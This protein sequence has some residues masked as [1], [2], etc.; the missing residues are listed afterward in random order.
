MRVSLKPEAI[1]ALKSKGPK[2]DPIPA[3][4]HQAY[5]VGVIDCGTHPDEYQGKKRDRQML[6]LIFELPALINEDGEPRMTGSY[7][8][9]SNSEKSTLIKLVN[10]WRGS[11]MTAAQL[12]EFCPSSLISRPCVVTIS[13]TESD[14]KTYDNVVAIAKPMQGMTFPPM[15]SKPVVF[16]IDEFDQAKF[17]ALPDFLKDKIVASYEYKARGTPAQASQGGQAAPAPEGEIPW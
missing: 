8:T 14:G 10:A 17:D 11:A 13:H 5:V 6:R 15:K 9:N 4:M 2:Y 3:G 7:Y 1:L 16:D 12:A